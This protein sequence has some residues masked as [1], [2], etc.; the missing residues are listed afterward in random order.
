MTWVFKVTH[1]LIMLGSVSDL[2]KEEE[3]LFQI[4]SCMNL[5]R[6]LTSEELIILTMSSIFCI[7]SSKPALTFREEAAVLLEICKKKTW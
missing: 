7:T 2:T 4:S 6:L 1:T 3:A 5:G